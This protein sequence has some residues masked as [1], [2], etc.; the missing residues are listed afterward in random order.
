M[1]T[2]V[3][4]LKDTE[5]DSDICSLAGMLERHGKK[6][7][8]ENPAEVREN[9]EEMLVI[10]DD[11]ED[12]RYA[13]KKNIALIFYEKPGEDSHVSGVDMI[14]Q[15]FQEV[16]IKFLQLVY[17]R[18]HRLPWPVAETERLYIRE[19]VE[20]DL[21]IFRCLYKE[22]GITDYIPEPELEGEDGHKRFCQYIDKMYRFFN[23]GI[24]TVVEK[25][26]GS[27]IGRAGIENREYRGENVLELGYLIGKRWQGK[28]YGEEAARAVEGF[29]ENVLEPENLYA[30]I[31][32][33]N[34]A[35]IHLIEKMEY[36]KLPE[37]TEDGLT[38]WV[39]EFEREGRKGR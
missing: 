11:A 27:I 20:E 25:E 31:Y 36:R 9:T 33:E 34:A 29:A 7:Y 14:V 24:W 3:F 18:H 38:V 2:V 22:K 16:D 19:S 28:G 6:I 5:H 4:H 39:K 26:H 13:R 8:Y 21:E 1:R 17:M 15:G 37:M 10:T 30:F 23:Y 32:P 12:V 35:S